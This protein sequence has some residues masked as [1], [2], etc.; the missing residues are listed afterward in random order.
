M[1]DSPKT[2]ITKHPAEDVDSWEGFLKRT[3]SQGGDSSDESPS[4]RRDRRLSH[5]HH[6][7]SHK[8]ERDHAEKVEREKEEQFETNYAKKQKTDANL[9]AKQLKQHEETLKEVWA[10]PGVR[11][12]TTHG[13]MID[14]GSTGSRMHVFEWAPRVLSSQADIEL[15]VSGS[16]L[17]FP[18][19]N[20]R[21]TD[22]LQPGIATFAAVQND[23]ELRDAVAEYLEPLL[24]FA[25]AV[26]H[27]KTGS[28]PEYPIFLRATAGMRIL[29]DPDRARVMR[30]VRELFN[31]KTYCPFNFVNEQARVLSGEE[32]SIYD[33][34][35]VNFLLGDLIEQSEGIGT[36]VNPKRTHGALDLGGASTQISFY[37]P[38]ED[39]MANLF[40]LQIGQ[41]RHWNV[42]AHS[43]LFYGMNEATNRL[44][45]RLAA[46]KTSDERMVEGIYNPC[47]PGGAKA[48]FRTNIHVD[49]KGLETWNYSGSYPSGDGYYQ[50]V[51]KNDKSKGDFSTCMDLTKALLNLEK[52]SWCDFAHKG[53]CSFAGIYQPPLPPDDEFV[54]FSNYYH[55][56]KF[57]GLPE[58]AT[59]TELH[60]ATQTVC[61]MSRSE[62]VKYNK[63]L[64]KPVDDDDLDSFC[65]RS[66]YAFQLLHNGYGFQMNNTIRATKVID[67][68]KVGWALGAM[69]YEINA[70]PWT[71]K[72]D[73]PFAVAIGSGDPALG[74]G[75]RS[76]ILFLAAVALGLLALLM[77]LLGR[78][79]RRDK[80]LHEYEVIQDATTKDERSP[81]TLSA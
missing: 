75:G 5:G 28:F 52:N 57:L 71:Y 77:L 35:G 13:L 70:L 58:R 50:A 39:V 81:L 48:E 63:G 29:E 73:S 15:A 59:L 78:G 80:K 26:L 42:Y 61:G 55:V 3:A 56:W 68:H 79:R 36:V 49:A 60:D 62:L 11:S 67:G 44:Q 53:D 6:H 20:A 45:A 31:N 74:K 4:G 65:F 10:N 69:L 1:N 46:G 41:A 23:Q 40:K 54:A 72:T 16:K 7:S 25:K 22:R 2:M 30:A 9:R 32:E 8:H 66:V 14:A 19:S 33:W 24:D 21:W 37:E 18:D 27:S 47:L 34:T 17:S 38:S 12:E 51:L 76:E 43:F 64:K